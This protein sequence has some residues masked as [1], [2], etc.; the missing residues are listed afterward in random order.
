MIVKLLFIVLL[1]KLCDNLMNAKSEQL[2]CEDLKKSNILGRIF[3]TAARFLSPKDFKVNFYG[4]TR[5][6]RKHI[7]ID[8]N[9]ITTLNN[10]GFDPSLKTVLLVHGYWSNG[11]KNWVINLKDKLLDAVSI[12]KISIRVRVVAPN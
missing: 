3:Y 5:K 10:T 11:T 9:N 6:H 1:I 2:K 4:C 8:V 12:L 7:L